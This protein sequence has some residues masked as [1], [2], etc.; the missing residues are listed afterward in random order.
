MK[1][2]FILY[3]SDI[4]ITKLFLKKISN[5]SNLHIQ[6]NFIRKLSEENIKN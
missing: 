4:L 3:Y 1:I 5:F 6:N 2:Y